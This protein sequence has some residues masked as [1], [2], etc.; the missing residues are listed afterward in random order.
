MK[1]KLTVKNKVMNAAT[2]VKLSKLVSTQLTQ[3]ET[4]I[5]QID[6]QVSDITHA[7]HTGL[8][9]CHVKFEFARF[10]RHIGKS[11]R[12]RLAPSIKTRTQ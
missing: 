9:L 12:K 2:R 6:V 10:T 5:R 3:Y 1:L 8:K 4:N 11:Q 7:Q